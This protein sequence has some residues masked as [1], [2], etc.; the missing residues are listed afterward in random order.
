MSE[1]LLQRW[2]SSEKALSELR[3]E[4]KAAVSALNEKYV[5]I[6]CRAG[7]LISLRLDNSDINAEHKSGLSVPCGDGVALG[8]ETTFK[9]VDGPQH[10][11]G[12][13]DSVREIAILMAKLEEQKEKEKES[14]KERM[15]EHNETV[16]ECK[17]AFLSQEMDGNVEWTKDG[18]QYK[19][20]AKL[21]TK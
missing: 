3:K 11:D 16:K 21:K 6:Q 2:K 13:P 8:V 7:E 14:F 19:L 17:N 18:V 12:N 1:E 4:R 15:R 10:S 20:T 9:I 5:D